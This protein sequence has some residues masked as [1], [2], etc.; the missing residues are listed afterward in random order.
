LDSILQSLKNAKYMEFEDAL[1]VVMKCMCNPPTYY[2][3]VNLL[4]SLMFLIINIT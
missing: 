2:A 4:F 3:K 1:K